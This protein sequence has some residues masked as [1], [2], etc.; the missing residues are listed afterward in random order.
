MRRAAET[1]VGGPADSVPLPLLWACFPVELCHGQGEHAIAPVAEHTPLGVH[2]ALPPPPA[3]PPPALSSPAL[4][5]KELPSEHVRASEPGV[6][7]PG[8]RFVG[9]TPPGA[10]VWSSR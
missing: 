6:A 4:P 5:G 10:S 2:A 9:V 8:S 1:S 3:L 7:P